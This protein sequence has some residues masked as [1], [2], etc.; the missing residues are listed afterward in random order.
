MGEAG[1][2]ER[3]E[4]RITDLHR[5]GAQPGNRYSDIAPANLD[6]PSEGPRRPWCTTPALLV[7]DLARRPER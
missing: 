2:D 4:D 6:L 1:R 5:A 3:A 7:F